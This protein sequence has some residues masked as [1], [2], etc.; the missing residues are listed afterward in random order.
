[1]QQIMDFSDEIVVPSNA[2]LVQFVPI[3]LLFL[4]VYNVEV[5]ALLRSEFAKRLELIHQT[6]SSWYFTMVLG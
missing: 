3:W 5:L 1:M 4:R 2:V 6:F